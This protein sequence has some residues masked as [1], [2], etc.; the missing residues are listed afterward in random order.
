M[1]QCIKC[2]KSIPDGELFCKECND[3]PVI[4]SLRTGKTENIAKP[5][6]KKPPVKQP[7]SSV[8]KKPAGPS[9]KKPFIVVCVLLALC[10]GLLLWQQASLGVKKNALRTEKEKLQHDYAAA[11]SKLLELEETKEEL[12]EAKL[13]IAK[14]EAEIKDLTDQLAD[15]KSS[16]N[17]GQYD[18]TQM[19]KERNE[20]QEEYD[21]LTEEYEK[22]QE[23]LEEAKNY[24]DKSDF[25]DK[26]V[27][28]VPT[29]G[30]VYH[31]YECSDFSRSSFW[32]YSPKLADRMGFKP[33]PKCN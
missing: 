17:Q 11:E 9:M 1:T 2:G 32:C 5:A 15:S 27:V 14:K 30:N 28:F 10:L 8:R 18:L 7:Q 25:L 29:S 21:A 3:L 33:C 12:E 24:K 23:E 31:R 26:Y 16:Q 22:A 20:L 6:V 13:T 19:E 4:A